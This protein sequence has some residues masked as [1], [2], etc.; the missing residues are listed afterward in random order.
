MDLGLAGRT[1]LVTGATTGIGRHTAL[2]FAEEGARL[3]FTFASNRAAADSLVEEIQQHGGQA[4]GLH[5]DFRSPDSVAAALDQAQRAGPV[6]VLVNNAVTWDE[7][8]ATGCDLWRDRIR[9]NLEGYFQCCTTL[10]PGMVERNWGRVVS[11]SSNLAEDGIPGSAAYSAAKAGVHGMMR[12]MM[13]DVGPHG[14]LLNIVMPGLT[15]TER[16][17]SDEHTPEH[18]REWER[19]RTPTSR[20]STPEDVARLIVYLGSNANQNITGEVIR[21]TGG[22]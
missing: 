15:L 11:L 18:V 4:V 12:G 13:W 1:V 6:D 8:H 10:M 14:V 3:L 7:Q 19:K 20:L 16:A 9:A 22:R 21:V 2:C 5:M 17:L